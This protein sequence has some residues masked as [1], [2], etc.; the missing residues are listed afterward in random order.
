M[1]HKIQ[2]IQSFVLN[3]YLI[4]TV[5]KSRRGL[6][7]VKDRSYHGICTIHAFIF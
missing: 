7:K 3:P 6:A 5:C 2:D 1:T 4:L